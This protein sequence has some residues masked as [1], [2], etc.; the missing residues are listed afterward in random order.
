MLTHAEF[1]GRVTP[2]DAGLGRMLS[3]QKADFIGKRLST[4]YGLTAA[5]RMQLVGLKPVDA[6]KDMRAGAHLLKEG[7]KPST[8]ND[9]GWVSSAG[10]SPVLG[11]AIAL[12]FLKSGRERYGEKVI[13][14]DKL[15]DQ[16]IVAEVCDPVFVD[17]QN[18]KLKA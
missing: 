11:H 15:R 10:F 14:F 6:D 1:D 7:T 9:Q 17:P 4:R 5:D 16:E 18:M 2:D 3:M 13:V 12:A 8:L